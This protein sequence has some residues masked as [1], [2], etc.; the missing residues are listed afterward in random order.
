[1]RKLVK[2]D[3][4]RGLLVLVFIGASLGVPKAIFAVGT[5]PLFV[6]TSSA[7][8]GKSKEVKAAKKREALKRSKKAQTATKKMAKNPDPF[9]KSKLL[10]KIYKRQAKRMKRISEFKKQG[11]IG[12]ADNGLLKVR[13]VGK[14]KAKD[15]EL[16]EKLVKVENSDRQKIFSEMEKDASYTKSNKV[17]LRRRYF[18]LYRQMD[19]RG[20]YFFQ[21]D[22]WHKK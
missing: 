20:T 18:E 13:E 8:A 22:H 19:S 11:V 21:A 7:F 6:S 17:F 5:F 16:M 9:Y 10:D 4:K 3:L 14:L 1:M 15:K 2:E 12:E